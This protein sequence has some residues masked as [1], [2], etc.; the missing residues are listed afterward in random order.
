MKKIILGK[1][2]ESFKP[3]IIIIHFHKG[4]FLIIFPLSLNRYSLFRLFKGISSV[5]YSILANP[6]IICSHS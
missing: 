3:V 1:I 6:T 2:I 5:L 4:M